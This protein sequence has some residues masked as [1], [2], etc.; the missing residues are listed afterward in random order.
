MDANIL[1]KIIRII[2]TAQ[3]LNRK[4]GFV[5]DST[6]AEINGIKGRLVWDYILINEISF[7]D[8]DGNIMSLFTSASDKAT[9]AKWNEFVKKMEPRDAHFR[10]RH[11]L[12]CMYLLSSLIFGIH[13]DLLN[14][15]FIVHKKF[16]REVLVLKIRKLTNQLKPPCPKCPYTLGLVHTVNNPCP[17]CK[18]DGYQMFERFKKHVSGEALD[19]DLPHLR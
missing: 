11:L 4:F 5:H 1:G 10:M 19:S 12:S 7:E 2:P 16:R 8:M 9:Q 3:I 14:R 15:S 13:Q 18:A 17:E 6:T